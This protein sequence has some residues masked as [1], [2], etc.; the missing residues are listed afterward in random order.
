M[1]EKN[2]EINIREF[3]MSQIIFYLN[4]INFELI[5]DLNNFTDGQLEEIFEYLLDTSKMIL[6]IKD[7]NKKID[8]GF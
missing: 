8:V 7:I 3:Y 1:V 4:S 5:D 2:L 6:K